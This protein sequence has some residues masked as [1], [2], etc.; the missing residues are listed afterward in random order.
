M[1]VIKTA[2]GKKTIKLS[3]SEWQSIGKKAGWMKKAEKNVGS[4][5]AF[6]VEEK[7]GGDG[8]G[9]LNISFDKKPSISVTIAPEQVQ[10]VKDLIE[11][12]TWKLRDIY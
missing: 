2:S 7:V 11:E 8:G 4:A 12:T 1:K 9:W 10:K 6:S 3:K 5:L